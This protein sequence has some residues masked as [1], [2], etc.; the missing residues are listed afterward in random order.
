MDTLPT[1]IIRVI[2][3]KLSNKDLAQTACTC[4]S[5]NHFAKQEQSI[6][7]KNLIIESS[8]IRQAVVSNDKKVT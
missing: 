7:T 1:D 8:K 3:S 6:R 4:G 5:L 2:L